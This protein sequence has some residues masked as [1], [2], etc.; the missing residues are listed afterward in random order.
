MNDFTYSA[1]NNGAYKAGFSSKQAVYELA[2]ETYF[3]AFDKLETVLSKNKWLCGSTV[4]E[5]D[6]RLF[7]TIYRHDPVYHNRMKLNQAFVSDYPHLWRWMCD[8]YALPGVAAA[9]PLSHMKQGYFGR[10][11]NGTVPVGPKGYPDL[12]LDREYAARR[13]TAG[14]YQGAEAPA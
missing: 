4:T 7:P 12:L 10:T 5:A 14:K 9:S 11:G 3:A 6:L 13:A 1:I 2:Y 8:F